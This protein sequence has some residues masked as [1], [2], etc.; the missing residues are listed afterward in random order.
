MNNEVET[1]S[2]PY[3]GIMILNELT[4]LSICRKR[5]GVSVPYRGIM[6]LNRTNRR[7]SSSKDLVSVPYRGIMILNKKTQLMQDIISTVSVPY[8]GIMILNYTDDMYKA[9]KNMFPSPIGEL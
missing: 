1:V 5:H 7:Q 9:A 3:R 8:R 2:V 6:I 4:K